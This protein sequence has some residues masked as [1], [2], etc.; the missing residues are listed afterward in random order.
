M[1]AQTGDNHLRIRKSLRK[2]AH[3]TPREMAPDLNQNNWDEN[4]TP[5]ILLILCLKYGKEN[6]IVFVSVNASRFGKPTFF[7]H[8]E[9]QKIFGVIPYSFEKALVLFL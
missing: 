9:I 1:L 8:V 3:G 5:L 2:P 6:Q 7:S 4:P